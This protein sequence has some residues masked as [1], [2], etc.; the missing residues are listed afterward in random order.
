MKA[1]LT[2]AA[3]VLIAGLSSASEHADS[4][5]VAKIEAILAEMQCQMDPEDIEVE[6]DG[7]DLDDVICKGGAQFDIKLDSEFNEV[8]RRAE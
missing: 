4:A 3:A 2:I 5:T 6:D 8:S 7:Y 1:L